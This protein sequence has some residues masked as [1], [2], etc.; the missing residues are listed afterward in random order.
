VKELR[1]MGIDDSRV[2]AYL[3][4]AEARLANDEDPCDSLA[5]VTHLEALGADWRVPHDYGLPGEGRPAS[6]PANPAAL[7][8]AR[9]GTYLEWGQA[10]LANGEDPR[11]AAAFVKHL[12]ALGADWRVPHQYG[13]PFVEQSAPEPTVVDR[14]GVD[15]WP[16]IKAAADRHSLPPLAVAAM[17]QA[18]SGL[19][20]RAERWGDRTRE[21]KESIGSPERLRQIVADLEARGLGADISFG[22]CQLTVGTAKWYQIGDGSNRVENVLRVRDALF[23]RATAIDIGTRH[24]ASAMTQAKRSDPNREGG[25][26]ILGGLVVYN[27]GWLPPSTHD[28]W[29]R[30]AGNVNNYQR[31]LAWARESLKLG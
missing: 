29:R 15:L 13:L 21:A 18:E 5:F 20:S 7:D 10:R 8:R 16:F 17:L 1:A 23:D 26:L 12:E 9:L 2:R 6:G 24:L 30:W 4:W 14:E 28:W 3:E 27:A 25:D 31:A 19:S 22:L 11:D